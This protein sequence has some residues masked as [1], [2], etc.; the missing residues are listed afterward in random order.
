[1][2]KKKFK[3]HFSK[4][5]TLKGISESNYDNYIDPKIKNFLPN[6]FIFKDMEEAIKIYFILSIKIK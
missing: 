6:P 1:M 2:S 3:S 5:L 4:I